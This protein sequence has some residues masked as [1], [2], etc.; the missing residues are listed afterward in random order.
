MKK[1]KGWADVRALYLDRSPASQ[2]LSS[3][4]TEGFALLD[5]YSR[6][7]AEKD[8]L[9]NIDAMLSWKQPRSLE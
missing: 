4:G 6:L 3:V 5:R 1:V 8:T 7:D 9:V 2:F